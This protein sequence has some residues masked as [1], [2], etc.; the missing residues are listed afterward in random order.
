MPIDG[1]LFTFSELAEDVL[2]EFM[3]RMEERTMIPHILA[4]F[5]VEGVGVQTLL[6]QLNLPADFPGAYVLI[7]G[8]KP[9][10]VGIS[11]TVIQ[12]LRQHVLGNTHFEASLAYKMAAAQNPHELTRNEAMENDGFRHHFE[13]AR[14]YIRT[15]KVAFIEIETPLERYLFEPF[16]AME[17]DTSEWNTFDTH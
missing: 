4:D 2:P 17:L 13:A 6:E 9:I 8:E 15:L 16:C 14:D 3:R 5:A 7:D 11:R 12:R 10:Y 1:C